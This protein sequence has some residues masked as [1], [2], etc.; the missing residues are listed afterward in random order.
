MCFIHLNTHWYQR[1]SRL[2]VVL[3]IV[4]LIWR[5]SLHSPPLA[6]VLFLFN[7]VFYVFTFE[8]INCSV[9]ILICWFVQ[10]SPLCFAFVELC[11]YTV[12]NI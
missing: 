6:Y 1:F 5:T 11:D 2:F 7:N 12:A 10:D 4:F 9:F 3:L 8:M